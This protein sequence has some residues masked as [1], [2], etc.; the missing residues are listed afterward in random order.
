MI[1]GIKK[2]YYVSRY[3]DKSFVTLLTRPSPYLY[4][5]LS[6]SPLLYIRSFRPLHIVVLTFFSQGFVYSRI[7]LCQDDSHAWRSSDK[8][9]KDQILRQPGAYATYN[10]RLNPTLPQA[11]RSNAPSASQSNSRNPQTFYYHRFNR[12]ETCNPRGCRYMHISI[13]V[14]LHPSIVCTTSA[15]IAISL[16]ITVRVSLPSTTRS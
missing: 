8:Q 6:R 7:Q 2:C 16:K 9:L 4:R 13:C 3:T 14:Q 5:D 11:K 12:N 15:S 10:T 1:K